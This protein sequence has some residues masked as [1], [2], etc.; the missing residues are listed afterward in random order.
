MNIPRIPHWACISNSAELIHCTAD[1]C[2]HREAAQKK[3]RGAKTALYKILSAEL[4]NQAQETKE[5]NTSTTSLTKKEVKKAGM[6]AA[7]VATAH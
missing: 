4:G 5:L 2:I 6:S 3:S 7:R 1:I